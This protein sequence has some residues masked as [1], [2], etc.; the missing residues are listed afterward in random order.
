MMTRFTFYIVIG[1]LL[2]SVLYTLMKGPSLRKNVKGKEEPEEL[3]QDPYCRTYI[4]KRSAMKKRIDGKDCHF[5]SAECLKKY[6]EKMMKERDFNASCASSKN[7]L[8]L[9][10]TFLRNLL[11]QIT[12]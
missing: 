2:S 10:S 12:N 4:P 9:F 7:G 1:F 8:F 3:V 5:C 6:L 11:K